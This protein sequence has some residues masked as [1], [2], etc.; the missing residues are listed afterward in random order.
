MDPLEQVV[1]RMSDLDNKLTDTVVPGFAVL[2]VDSL[3]P[4]NKVFGNNSA[5]DFVV[6][7]ADIDVV[8]FVDDHFQR[9]DCRNWAFVLLQRMD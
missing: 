9:P 3:A 2:A 6:D 8:A 4:D 7:A 1:G 5:S